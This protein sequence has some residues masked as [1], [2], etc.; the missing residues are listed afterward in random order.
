MV[1]GTKEGYPKLIG[2]F[3]TLL[4]DIIWVGVGATADLV[5]ATALTAGVT[6]DDT[7]GHI[8]VNVQN[9]NA[10]RLEGF[11]VAITDSE[12]TVIYWDGFALNAELTTTTADGIGGFFNVDAGNYQVTVE[13]DG[14][15]CTNSPWSWAAGSGYA[16]PVEAGA[17][18]NIAVTCFDEA[19]ATEGGEE[20]TEGGEE[21]TEG[22]EEATEEG[23]EEATESCYEKLMLLKNGV[24]GEINLELCDLTVNYVTTYTAMEGEEEVVTSF[25]FFVSGMD[26]EGL[27]TAASQIYVT[28]AVT[29]QDDEGNDIIGFPYEIPQVGSIVNVTALKYENFNGQN[30]IT[31]SANLEVVSVGEAWTVSLVDFGVP[32]EDTESMVVY[33]DMTIVSGDANELGQIAGS[34]F[35]V[36]YGV[37][38]V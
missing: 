13:K 9:E 20:A 17:I 18:T 6:V 4:D 33:G 15:L 10:E 31:A 22:G 7:K 5:A 24:E 23:G 36:D 32:S 16:L 28:P 34:I 8:L 26:A 38:E 3:E 14:V 12:N 11:T 25:S 29:G 19:P 27:E 1:S 37:G 30:E 21:A 2:T 35:T